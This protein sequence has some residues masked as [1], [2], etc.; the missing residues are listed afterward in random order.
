MNQSPDPLRS[1]RRLAEEWLMESSSWRDNLDDVQAQRLM[2][3][4]RTYVNRIIAETA[5]LEDDEAEE[6]IDGA[7]TA[8]LRILRDIDKL[9]PLLSQLDEETSRQQ[10]QKFSKDLET[11]KLTAIPEETIQGMLTQKQTWDFTAT[12]NNLYQQLIPQTETQLS[13]EEEE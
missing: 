6:M 13:E 11:V 1:R 3:Q 5:V 2:N 7:V 4:A 9:T 8:V 12:F 10:L